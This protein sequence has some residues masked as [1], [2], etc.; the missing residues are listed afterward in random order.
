MGVKR[1]F[2]SCFRRKRLET[3]CSAEVV[4]LC[5]DAVGVAISLTSLGVGFF[6]GLG[7][8]VVLG[9]GRC[10]LVCI[11][12]VFLMLVCSGFGWCSVC[13]GFLSIEIVECS[14][15]WRLRV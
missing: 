14:V 15:V 5:I 13:S 10:G 2:P 7:C 12:G 11:F 3:S 9:L 6:V 1:L 8:G 4:T